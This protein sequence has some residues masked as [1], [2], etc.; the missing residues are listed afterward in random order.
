MTVFC[1]Q[2][3]QASVSKKF[4]LIGEIVSFD[5]ARV[6]IKSGRQEYVFLKQELDLPSYGAGNRI[7]VPC[8]LEKLDRARVK[9]MRKQTAS[10]ADISSSPKIKKRA[11]Q[12]GRVPMDTVARES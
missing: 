7:E 4:L 5:E 8:D 1:T 10:K 11:T 9:K 3:A 6:K 12:V 2:V